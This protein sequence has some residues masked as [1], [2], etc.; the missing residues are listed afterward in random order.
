MQ[1][2]LDNLRLTKAVDVFLKVLAE[3][4][5]GE[6]IAGTALEIKDG[7][8]LETD[9][10]GRVAEAVF[11]IDFPR[12]PT[13]AVLE[14]YTGIVGLQGMLS[15]GVLYSV[16][17]SVNL[18]HGELGTFAAAHGLDGYTIGSNPFF[19]ELAENAFTVSFVEPG[20]PHSDHL[21]R[22]FGDA[23]A[24]VR[25]TFRVHPNEAD[26][27]RM[28][29]AGGTPTAFQRI[30]EELGQIGLRY[31]PW[32]VSRV[33]AF[34]LPQR[35][36]IERESRLMLKRHEGA[37]DLTVPRHGT[38]IWPIEIVKPGALVSDSACSVEL[39]DVVT[40]DGCDADKVRK[41]LESSRYARVPVLER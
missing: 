25:L 15:E 34:Y 8:L 7:L 17:A 20:H 13:P 29:Y 12:L 39:L 5:P 22:Q 16:P 27:R 28:N 41:M 23:G 37:P 31:V 6:V 4:C 40:G 3:R 11:G 24:G 33:G 32:G 21:W 35:F 19:R 36:A 38:Q 1:R 2:P 10:G 26:L 9:R 18:V 30:N 14:H